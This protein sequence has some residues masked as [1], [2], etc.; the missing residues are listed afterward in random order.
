MIIPPRTE[1]RPRSL[2]AVRGAMDWRAFAVAAATFLAAVA[3][4]IFLVAHLAP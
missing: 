4:F 3:A 1:S 2:H